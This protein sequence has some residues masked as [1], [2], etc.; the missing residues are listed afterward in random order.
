[1]IYDIQASQ[2]VL[3]I[4]N[5]EELKDICKGYEPTISQKSFTNL[6]KAKQKDGRVQAM[7]IE[8]KGDLFTALLL[9]DSNGPYFSFILASEMG[10]E[11]EIR[12]GMK[13]ASMQG[14]RTGQFRI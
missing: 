4:A 7:I 11:E 5:W 14:I 13:H 2:E 3:K 1:M 8:W 9:K 6:E 10:K 12:E